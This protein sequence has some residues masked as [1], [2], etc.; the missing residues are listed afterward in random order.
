[1]AQ[2]LLPLVAAGRVAKVTYPGLPDHPDRALVERQMTGGGCML[3]IELPGGLPGVRKAFDRLQHVARAASLG[4]VESLATL[5]AFTTH[6]A[7]SAARAQAGIPD[8]LLRVAVHE[9]AEVLLHDLRQA[10]G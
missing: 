5:P 4:G 6:A 9:G 10:I 1:M 3:A 7:L 2:G 8:G